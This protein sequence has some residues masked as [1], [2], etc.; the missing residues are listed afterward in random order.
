MKKN[1]K[2][3]LLG[4][5]LLLII[6]LAVI[7]T[8][9]LV[10]KMTHPAE[11]EVKESFDDSFTGTLSNAY[12]VSNCEN[13]I[14]VLYHQ[15]YYVANETAQSAYTGVA[16]IE[17]EHGKIVKIQSKSGSVSGILASYSPNTVQIEGYQPLSCDETLP[18]YYVDE[19]EK[20]GLPVRQISVSDLVIGNSSLDLIVAEGRACA[21][22]KH[23]S[24]KVDNVR[25]LLKNGSSLFY[26]NLY[27]KSNR[28]YAVDG[29]TKD[30]GTIV[31]A[32]DCLKGCKNGK[33]IR[34]SSKNNGMLFL[35]NESGKKEKE[36]Y[37]GDFI[38][39]KEK[40]GIVL[41]NELPIE[42]YVRYVLPSEM[43][44]TFSYEA[45]KA[46]AVCARTFAYGQIHNDTYAKYG[47]NLDDSTAF[48]VY[49]ATK[50]YEITDQAVADTKGM[51]LTYEGKLVDCYYYSTSPG[52][53]ENLEVWD[54]ES[55]NYL[56]AENHT[57][58]N[59]INLSKKKN[60][61]KF[62][63]NDVA[64]YDS[65]SPYYRWTA[66]LS[67][68]LGMDSE[69]GRLKKME[70]L[71]RSESG[72]VLS[73]KVVFEDGERI[74]EKENDIRFALGK[75]LLKVELADKTVRSD[76]HSVP[77]AC[78]EIKNQKDGT[79]VLSGGGFGHGIGMSQYGADAMAREG[80]NWQKILDYYYKGT[81]L[82][83]EK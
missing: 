9:F 14:I 25:V 34:I 17:M 73:L 3:K 57:K 6:I 4:I 23:Q 2:M 31:S 51:V 21:I 66:T 58:I 39:R 49:H 69:L 64:S 15:K 35:C 72:Y 67:S 10:S 60:F 55:P 62:I 8:F 47:A 46:Q 77:S 7:L 79:I 29:Q 61:H 36:G 56:V 74:Y 76:C 68:K 82:V 26:S 19:E 80:Q 40:G 65:D 43:P 41:I 78:F 38:L 70:V 33:E 27:I 59:K 63:T 42:D 22:V 53:S 13:E 1:D 28:S 30:A 45:L 44:V 52:Y 81:E 71:E 24:E 20:T 75:Y 11:T 16:D 54:A 50:S 5:G 12:I 48:Q 32:K 83:E 18:V 37:E